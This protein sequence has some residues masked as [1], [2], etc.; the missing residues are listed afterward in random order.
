MKKLLAVFIICTLMLQ[1]SEEQKAQVPQNTIE[2]ENAMLKQQVNLK[3][4]SLIQKLNEALRKKSTVVYKT[5]YRPK[6]VYVASDGK[7]IAGINS[8]EPCD[9]VFYLVKKKN[10]LQRMFGSQRADTIRVK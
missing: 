10:L 4:D 6:I 2:Q 9:T 5:R 7:A 1:P 8:G 3:Q